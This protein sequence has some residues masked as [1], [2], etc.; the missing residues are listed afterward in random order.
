MLQGGNWVL[1][2]MAL[3]ILL[4]IA[5]SV[6]PTIRDTEFYNVILYGLHIYTLYVYIF[7]DDHHIRCYE[8][9]L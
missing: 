9:N 3:A 4:M 7:S 1:C 6:I 2:P 5:R 8:L